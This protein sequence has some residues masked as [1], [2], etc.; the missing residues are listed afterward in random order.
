LLIHDLH[1]IL[2][3]IEIQPWQGIHKLG[4]WNYEINPDQGGNF[5]IV[6]IDTNGCIKEYPLYILLDLNDQLYYPNVFS[7]NADGVND[8]WNIHMGSAYT[9]GSLYVYDRWGAQVYAMPPSEIGNPKHGWNGQ[10]QGKNCPPGVYIFQA[11]LRDDKNQSR[12]KYGNFTLL[13]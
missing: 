1:Q 5:K 13:R 8:L 4:T 9:A 7:P 12:T 11:L 10:Y 3:E 2:A 6:A